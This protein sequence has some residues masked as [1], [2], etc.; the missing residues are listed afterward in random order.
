MLKTKQLGLYL[1]EGGDPLSVGPLNKNFELLDGE[2]T[3][4]GKV[5]QGSY[6]GGTSA[7]TPASC[8]DYYK[9]KFTRG[10]GEPNSRAE[11]LTITLD[12]VPKL[13]VLTGTLETEVAWES[14]TTGGDVGDNPAIFETS[15]SGVEYQLFDMTAHLG[16]ALCPVEFHSRYPWVWFNENNLYEFAWKEVCAEGC[17]RVE[18]ADNGDGTCTL[19]I[20]GVEEA[21][22]TVNWADVEGMTYHWTAIG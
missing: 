4:R 15:P 14:V 19:T 7:Q 17:C 11:D 10:L 22:G 21:Y 18:A 2:V 12:F 9:Q 6:T 1:P 5:A 8:M 3:R 20:R 16:R 13:F